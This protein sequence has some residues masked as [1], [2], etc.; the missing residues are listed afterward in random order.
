MSGGTDSSMV[1]SDA[2]ACRMAFSAAALALLA[3][4]LAVWPGPVGVSQ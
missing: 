3:L 4:I 2:K 1:S